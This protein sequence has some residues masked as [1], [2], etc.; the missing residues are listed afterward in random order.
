[1]VK[2]A[3]LMGKVSGETTGG[4]WHGSMMAGFTGMGGGWMW[5]G[6]I[7]WLVTW[8]LMVAVLVALLRWLWR[9]GNKK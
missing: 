5:L 4:I 7:F 6:G 8:V 2:I 3:H 1:M 9:K